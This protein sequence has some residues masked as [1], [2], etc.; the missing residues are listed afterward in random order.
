MSTSTDRRLDEMRDR[1]DGLQASAQKVE[2]KVQQLES[3]LKRVD[4]AVAAEL[5]E[6]RQ[7]FAVAIRAHR[8]GFT[9][10]KSQ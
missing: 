5:A 9:P 4:H 3:R 8:E 6:H 10:K 1:I 2:A 7:A